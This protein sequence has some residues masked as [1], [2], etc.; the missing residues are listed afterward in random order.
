MIRLATIDD[1]KQLFILNEQFNGKE[2]TSLENIKKS[3][4]N[5]NQEI[6]IVAEH[7]QIIVGFICVQIKK[8]FCYNEN[9]AEVSEVFVNENYRRRKFASKMIKFAEEYCIK[10]YLLHN[11]EIKTGKDNTGAQSLYK[12]LGY[13][14]SP[15]ILLRKRQYLDR[16][17]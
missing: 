15:E 17:K 14:I 1:A 4:L 9:Y 12:T 11:F 8:S 5:N 3:I 6:V 7:K 16:D 10:N 13:N 2:E